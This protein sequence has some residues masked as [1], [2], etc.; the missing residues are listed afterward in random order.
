VN[1]VLQR[2]WNEAVVACFKALSQH[3]P[4]T[5]KENHDKS[6]CIAGLRTKF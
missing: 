1:G 4:G 3:L 5:T 2:T 6:V